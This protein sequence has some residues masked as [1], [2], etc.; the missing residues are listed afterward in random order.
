MNEM[1]FRRDVVRLPIFGPRLRRRRA[2]PL[3]RRPDGRARR[4]GS[5]VLLIVV[6]FSS[7]AFRYDR[8]GQ[9]QSRRLRPVRR[10]QRRG[11]GAGERRRQRRAGITIG[12]GGEHC[13]PDTLDVMG[14]DV[15]GQGLDVIFKQSIPGDRR[16]RLSGGLGRLPR[17]GAGRCRW[18]R[19][20]GPAAIRAAPR[21]STS[22]RRCSAIR[23]WASMPSARCCART[24]TCRHRRCCSCSTRLI[25]SGTHA[26]L[27][28]ALLARSRLHGRLPDGAGRR[29][30]GQ[31]FLSIIRL[32]LPG[33]TRRSPPC[34]SRG[35]R[36]AGREDAGRRV[37][38]GDDAERARDG[39]P[40]DGEPC[41][42]RK[43]RFQRARDDLGRR[44]RSFVEADML[45]GG[46]GVAVGDRARAGA[47]EHGRDAGRT[48]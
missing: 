21:W 25:R 31:G 41:Q 20:T 48:A 4:S 24:A 18:P 6:E 2:R 9:E 17:A 42:G 47:I 5:R 16:A 19:S 29:R 8:P 26:A 13:W 3:P 35:R 12:A 30:G 28:A 45:V 38:P 23:R 10:W 11:G 39:K 27:P 46:M 44:L 37:K 1:P 15:D 14:W 36:G 33:L 22:L 7:L 34:R 43:Q 40:V 32:S